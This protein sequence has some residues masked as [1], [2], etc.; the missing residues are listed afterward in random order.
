MFGKA[1]FCKLSSAAELWLGTCPLV[2]VWGME[3]HLLFDCQQQ[4]VKSCFL[5]DVEGFVL[6]VKHYVFFAV[7]RFQKVLI[8]GVMKE[9]LT[10]L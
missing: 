8:L 3:L 9:Q 2:S 4:G 7:A 1:L 5:S 6:V 10:L